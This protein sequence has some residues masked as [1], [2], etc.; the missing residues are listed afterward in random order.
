M[1][2][3]ES[4]AMLTLAHLL[5]APEQRL[6][7]Q[8]RDNVSG[9]CVF[10][11]QPRLA[12][13]VAPPGGLHTLR[14][15]Q[16]KGWL[17]HKPELAYH[18]QDEYQVSDAAR[19]LFASDPDWRLAED[20]W[21]RSRASPSQL[22]EAGADAPF[23]A[24]AAVL[25]GALWIVQAYARARWS[26]ATWSTPW[27]WRP[28]ARPTPPSAGP[29]PGADLDPGARLDGAAGRTG[30]QGPRHARAEG[31]VSRTFGTLSRD[32]ATLGH[33]RPGA[34]RAH[35]AEVHVPEGAEDQP[36]ALRVP[37]D[38]ATAADLEWFTQRYPLALSRTRTRGR[39]P[40][41]RDAYEN[42][43]AEARGSSRRLPAAAFAGLQPGQEVRRTRRA[44]SSCCAGFGGVL[45][46]DD[47]GEGKTYTAGAACL[48]PGRAAGDHRRAA[49]PAL[50]WK[51]KLEEFTTLTSTW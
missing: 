36:A 44:T 3:L 28:W 32:G 35:P 24:R 51:R 43:Q 18:G 7:H 20:V 12:G 23:R 2:R 11:R 49:A 27:W 1:S 47:V 15:M 17:T 14:L 29:I 13:S 34:A 22:A 48:I 10:F 6:V 41:G 16:R 42:A 25:A 31:R 38:P 46:A 40:S 19:A 5:T 9:H 26:G 30:A 39:W 33:R 50:Q 4:S 8:H 37:G 45:V 21:P